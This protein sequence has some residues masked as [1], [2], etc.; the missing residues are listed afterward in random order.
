M[1]TGNTEW[2]RE[3]TST[4]GL[5]PAMSR[6]AAEQLE[7]TLGD[8]WYACHHQSPGGVRPDLELH[9]R[10]FD[11]VAQGK[12]L[13]EALQMIDPVRLPGPPARAQALRIDETRY[14]ITPEGRIAL[15]LISQSIRIR[16]SSITVN[17][18]IASQWERDLLDLY[19]D[20]GRYR[21]SSVIEL[22][23][24]GAKPLQIPAVGAVLTLMVN[25]SDSPRRAIARFPPG[26][27]RDVVDAVFRSCANAFANELTPKR[28]PNEKERLISGWTLG[29]ISRRMP[30]ALR[31]SDAEGVYIIPENEDELLGLLVG[32]LHRREVTEMGL[33]SAFDRLVDAFHAR[34]QDLAGY[35]LLFE[36]PAVTKELR[37]RLM[38]RWAAQN[39]PDSQ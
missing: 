16:G 21:L 24:G 7:E 32:E 9:K 38:G 34:S 33:A 1:S 11:P 13:R 25:R 37:R 29:E 23:G 4:F 17:Q 5:P 31:S 18:D 20:W 14:L 8:L 36:R 28:H 6:S 2:L 39:D 15:A 26:T 35:G 30:N 27:S 19:R 3:S 12:R 22:L 10:F